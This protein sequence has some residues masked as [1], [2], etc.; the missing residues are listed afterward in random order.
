MALKLQKWGGERKEL[1]NWKTYKVK[2]GRGL[3]KN[4]EEYLGCI[5]KG[6]REEGKLKMKETE[7]KYKHR[8]AKGKVVQEEACVQHSPM[9]PRQARYRVRSFHCIYC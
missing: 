8:K 3:G 1:Q 6:E 7:K 2:R 5:L 9:L 4:G